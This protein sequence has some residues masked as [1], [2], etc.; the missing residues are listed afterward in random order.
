MRPHRKN[1]FIFVRFFLVS[2]AVSGGEGKMRT[3]GIIVESSLVR[4]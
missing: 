4:T 3:S 2:K 1:M